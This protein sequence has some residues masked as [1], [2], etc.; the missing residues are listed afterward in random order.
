MGEFAWQPSGR[1]L[2]G[3]RVRNFMDLHGIRS[4][5]ELIGRSTRD[6]E[7]FW[8]SALEHL[9][10]EWFEKYTRLYDDSRGMPWTT[11]FSGGKLN[12]VHNCLDRHIREGR[13]AATALRFES[14][15]GSQSLLSYNRLF[16]SVNRLA[17]AMRSLGIHKG[18]RVAM[19][20]PISP[21]AVTVMLAALKLGTACIQMPARIG[22]EEIASRVQQ[23]QP[24]LLFVNDGYPRAG[25]AISSQ[26][27]YEAVLRS[28]PAIE[29]V[30]V[31][32]RRG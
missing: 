6:I 26:S 9:G 3:S 13:G 28:A 21:E 18:D 31:N 16:E 4:W 1:Y 5:Q 12:I 27:V 23:A 15:D 20:M 7:W 30:V 11:W 19:C 17:G 25:K 14:D 8:N 29:W 2:D 10:V 22:P 32:E 24:R